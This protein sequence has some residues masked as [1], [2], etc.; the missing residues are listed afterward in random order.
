MNNFNEPPAPPPHWVTNENERILALTREMIGAQ[1]MSKLYQDI[2]TSISEEKKRE[3]ANALADFAIQEINGNNFAIRGTLESA[4]ARD[5]NALVERHVL[6]IRDAVNEVFTSSKIQEMVEQ[7]V[8]DTQR[9]IQR[10]LGE[11]VSNALR[12]FRPLP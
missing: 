10:H 12:D 8:S 2:W 4:I 3:V 1:G 7:T 9:R 11:K 5:V 6:T